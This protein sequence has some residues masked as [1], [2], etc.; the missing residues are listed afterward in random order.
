MVYRQNGSN[1]LVS[2]KEPANLDFSRDFLN[3]QSKIMFTFLFERV[4][5]T[6][7]SKKLSIIARYTSESEY[8][9]INEAGREA[10][11]LL[12]MMK[13]ATTE[14]ELPTTVVFWIPLK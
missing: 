9:A 5:I 2:L 12:K 3:R 6:W 4:V 10:L 11:W 14:E 13:D 8:V 1:N 7:R